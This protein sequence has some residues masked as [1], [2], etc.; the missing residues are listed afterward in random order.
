MLKIHLF[1]TI[2][3]GESWMPLLLFGMEELVNN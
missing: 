1:V 2:L 3:M